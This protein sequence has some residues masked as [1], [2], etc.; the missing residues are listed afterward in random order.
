M[1]SG[2]WAVCD[3]LSSSS[4]NNSKCLKVRKVGL[5]PQSLNNLKQVSSRNPERGRT[6]EAC[7]AE[8]CLDLVGGHVA[9]VRVVDLVRLRRVG[10]FFGDPF[11]RRD[12]VDR[13]RLARFATALGVAA[14]AR[15]AWFCMH[16][17][18][19]PLAEG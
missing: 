5:P 11:G 10:E 7:D 19:R 1:S 8:H 14:R 15:A 9:R 2:Q 6:Q 17:R 12:V 13:A 18:G 3:E 4:K 16:A